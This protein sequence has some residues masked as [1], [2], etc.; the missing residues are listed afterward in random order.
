MEEEK[1][2]DEGGAINFETLAANYS[3]L[4]QF[5]RVGRITRAT[6]AVTRGKYARRSRVGIRTSSLA[7]N[8][9]ELV[10][11]IFFSRCVRLALVL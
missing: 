2:G 1:E 6:A 8:E 4:P 7:W 10:K 5:A 3:A 9:T 11:M